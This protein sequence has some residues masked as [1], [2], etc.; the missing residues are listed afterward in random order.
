[1]PK[2]LRKI[3]EI[4]PVKKGEELKKITRIEPRYNKT[5][6]KREKEVF[7]EYKRKHMELTKKLSNYKVQGK[8][9][10]E[11]Y[12]AYRKMNEA[13][14]QL[15]K[16]T[17]KPEERIKNMDAYNFT[18]TWYLT[19]LEKLPNEEKVKYLI[20]KLNSLQQIWKEQIEKEK[21]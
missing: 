5:V 4:K 1:M 15:M 6:E 21:K 19:E 7:N 11:M 2:Y 12:D 14:R 10:T 8:T 17:K 16:L 18:V 9:S 13:F 3:K 20:Q